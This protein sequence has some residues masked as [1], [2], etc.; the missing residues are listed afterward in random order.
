[1][2]DPVLRVDSSTRYHILRCIHIG[3]LCVQDNP[4][5]R[6]TMTSVVLMLSS[7]AIS[8]PAPFEPT[9]STTHGY[10]SRI[11]NLQAYVF[12]EFQSSGSSALKKSTQSTE[13][14]ES[15]M[16]TMY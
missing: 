16:S 3:L 11:A 14:L 9:Y 8:L 5:D 7:F 4:T 1:M 13:S 15:F 6:P 10:N 12:K 2:I